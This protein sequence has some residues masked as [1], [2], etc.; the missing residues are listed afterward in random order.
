MYR[1]GR[2]FHWKLLVSQ[3]SK[4]SSTCRLT[5][6]SLWSHVKSIYSKA[7]DRET[8]MLRNIPQVVHRHTGCRPQTG[9]PSCWETY[10]WWCTDTQEKSSCLKSAKTKI[11]RPG[12]KVGWNAEDRGGVGSCK[13]KKLKSTLPCLSLNDFM[14]KM[15]KTSQKDKSQMH[16]L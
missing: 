16:L 11:I 2:S 5:M 1:A 6:A 7:S 4:E 14:S 12:C 9:R 10:H 3:E 8:L 13:V 15:W